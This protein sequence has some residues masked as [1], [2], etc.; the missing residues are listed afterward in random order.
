MFKKRGNSSKN[1]ECLIEV[2][3]VVVDKQYWYKLVTK[4][5]GWMLYKANE[6]VTGFEAMQ[7]PSNAPTANRSPAFERVMEASPG[8]DPAMASKGNKNH[9]PYRV[10]DENVE[11]ITRIVTD[12]Q[13]QLVHLVN[14]MRSVRTATDLHQ[15]E[16]KKV[17]TKMD[18]FEGKRKAQEDTNNTRWVHRDAQIAESHQAIGELL[19]MVLSARGGLPPSTNI[20]SMPMS[21]LLRLANPMELE[22]SKRRKSIVKVKAS[23][24]KYGEDEELK[25]VLE[26]C[27]KEKERQYSRRVQHRGRE[28]SSL[29]RA[30]NSWRRTKIRCK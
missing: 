3:G 21:Q 26:E 4:L 10:M 27:L 7:I 22:N 29:I 19:K 25:T 11:S 23:L 14:E 8:M 15:V 24:A 30:S 1:L 9:Q 5:E 18:E 28:R 6:L 13:A 2:Q 16:L 20:Q 17:G 12:T